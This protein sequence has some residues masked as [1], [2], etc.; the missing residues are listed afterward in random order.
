M[1]ALAH[2]PLAPAEALQDR[3]RRHAVY[4]RGHAVLPDLRLVEIMVDD[5]SHDGCKIAVR[6]PLEAGDRIRLGVAQR[7]MIDAQVRWYANGKAGLVFEPEA[8]EG[9]QHRERQCERVALLADVTMRRL[10]KPN[11][12]VR[13]FDAS[14]HG[15][16]IE[17]VERPAVDELVRIRLHGLQPLDARI[18]W[19]ED[20]RAGL[21]FERPIH[22][23][24]FDLL[25]SRMVAEA[26]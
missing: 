22:P 7:A 5:L 24:V 15:C 12:R 19:I 1:S 20:N 11:F 26:G 17:Y 13:V 25:V 6:L 10:G 4:L 14:I 23:A 9:P 3:P 2:L 21:R 16:M 8:E 18:C